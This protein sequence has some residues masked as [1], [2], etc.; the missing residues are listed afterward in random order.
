MCATMTTI[1][2]GARYAE[3]IT[4]QHFFCKKCKVII[5]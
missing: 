3:Q 1:P 5:S 4:A 2:E